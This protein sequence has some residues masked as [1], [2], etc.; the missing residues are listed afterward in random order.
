MLLGQLCSFFLLYSTPAH[1]I[2]SLAPDLG[3]HLSAFPL[4]LLP[5]PGVLES[6]E[7]ITQ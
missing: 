2:E 5:P 6:L 7:Y 4:G 3:D 1:E